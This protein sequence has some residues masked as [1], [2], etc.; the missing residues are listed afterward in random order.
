MS[1]LPKALCMFPQGGNTESL[2]YQIVI[3]VVP[4]VPDRQV[5]EETV[6]CTQDVVR[7]GPHLSTQIDHDPHPPVPDPGASAHMEV[8]HHIPQYLCC[9]TRRNIL[10]PLF[11]FQA[12]KV[13][14]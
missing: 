6:V 10:V 2:K 12:R 5:P 14:V 4:G 1:A 7:L 9:K 8:L 3:L 11:S 13:D